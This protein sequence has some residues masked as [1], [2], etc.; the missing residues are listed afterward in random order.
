MTATVTDAHTNNPATAMVNVTNATAMVT[1]TTATDTTTN[2]TSA[3]DAPSAA[4]IDITTGMGTASMTTSAIV[5]MDS[6]SRSV[7]NPEA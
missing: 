5:D 4:A 1:N 2:T 7:R 6:G 3:T